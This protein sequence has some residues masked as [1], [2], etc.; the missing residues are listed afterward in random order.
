MCI[1]SIIQQL[2]KMHDREKVQ[3]WSC[4]QHLCMQ[5]I[6]LFKW[7]KNRMFYMW[8]K[9]VRLH[10]LLFTVSVYIMRFIEKLESKLFSIRMHMYGE[11]LFERQWVFEMHSI[12]SILRIML[13]TKIGCELWPL[14]CWFYLQS[15][16]K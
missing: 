3:C 4:Q 12:C 1:M 7:L 13:P 10:K 14:Q 11:L 8:V 5:T 2:F 9:D 15:D 16:D 6:H